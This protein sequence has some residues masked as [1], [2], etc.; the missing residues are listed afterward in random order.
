MSLRSRWLEDDPDIY[1]VR[2]H[3][4]R[5][6]NTTGGS[7]PFRFKVSAGGSTYTDGISGSENGT[8]D[9]SV[10]HDAQHH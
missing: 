5:F 8:Q 4:Y 3:K 10:Q 1:L 6:A 7:Y 9:F 2:G